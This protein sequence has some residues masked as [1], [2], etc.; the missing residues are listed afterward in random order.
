MRK[1][2]KRRCREGILQRGVQKPRRTGQRDLSLIG[3]SI[4]LGKVF[5][6]FQ[7]RHWIKKIRKTQQFWLV[8]AQNSDRCLSF[9]GV[10]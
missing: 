5:Q 2:Q 6:N 1:R 3:F 8:L 4:K 10:V 7:M 9:E